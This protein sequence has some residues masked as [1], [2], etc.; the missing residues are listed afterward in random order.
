MSLYLQNAY[1]LMVKKIK[2]VL[3]G[4]SQVSTTADIWMTEVEYEL[5]PHQHCD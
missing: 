3:E 1:E 2:E 4:V 5:P